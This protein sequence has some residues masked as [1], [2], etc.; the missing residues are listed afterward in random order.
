LKSKKVVVSVINDL[1]TDQRVARVCNSLYESGFEV[2]L[3]GRSLKTSLPMDR[4]PYKVK[5]MKLL[6]SSG[7][8]FYLEYTI[9]LFLELACIKADV[10][11]SNDLDT[12]LPNCIIAKLKR[13]KLVYDSH[14]YFTEVPELQTH[15][16]KKRIWSFI[17]SLCFRHANIIFTVN[18][19]IAD[20]YTKQYQKEVLV[21]RNF[22]YKRT[23]T[24]TYT[25]SDFSIREDVK[26]IIL[27]GSGIN[28]DRGAEEAVDAMQYINGAVLVIAGG[29]DV[30]PILR[31]TVREKQL[32]DKVIF[33]PKLPYH[34]LIQLTSLADVGLSL[35]KDTNLNYRY[36]LPNKLFD[37][38]QAGIPI[39]ASPLPEIKRIIEEYEVGICIENHE[40]DELVSK[41]NFILYEKPKYIWKKNLNIASEKLC[42]ELEK[43]KLIDP[44]E[45][46][47]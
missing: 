44:Y 13:K 42:W 10:F 20:I 30:I 5:R 31:E 15:P 23:V 46:I 21:V 2:I 8:L 22:P 25:K 35:D 17:E 47:L 14:E 16:T 41:I 24:Q 34:T 33:I 38:I 3:I 26:L 29:G 11:H 12:L 32:E 1:V 9:R 37:Y 39:I 45:Q 19:S 4:R 27:Q 7:P 28:I 36:S 43:H 40:S 18:N 6:F